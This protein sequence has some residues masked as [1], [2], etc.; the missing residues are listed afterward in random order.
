MILKGFRSLWLARD[1]E[2][3]CEERASRCYNNDIT[4]LQGT[5]QTLLQ[6]IKERDA[7]KVSVRLASALDIAIIQVMDEA[8]NGT[9]LSKI[10]QAILPDNGVDK[11]SSYSVPLEIMPAGQFESPYKTI[12]VQLQES[13]QGG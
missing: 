4:I 9:K 8:Y 7:D 12:C 3:I 6:S 11:N 5:L 1:S 10:N 13:K 2:S